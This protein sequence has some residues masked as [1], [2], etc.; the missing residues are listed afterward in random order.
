[1]SDKPTAVTDE[2]KQRLP[3]VWRGLYIALVENK[4]TIDKLKADVERLRKACMYARGSVHTK[5]K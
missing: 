5:G 3:G 1:M 4:A 2:M